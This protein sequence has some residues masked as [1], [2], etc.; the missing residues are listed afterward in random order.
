MAVNESANQSYCSKYIYN[1]NFQEVWKRD[2]RDGE[3][4]CC[5]IE[6]L[7]ISFNEMLY[8]FIHGS[9]KI[10]RKWRARRITLYAMSI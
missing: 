1:G 9:Q 3:S 4:D 8:L 10:T 7:K 6:I 5:G 2:I